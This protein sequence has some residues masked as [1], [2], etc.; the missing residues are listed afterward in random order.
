MN[1]LSDGVW[2][3]LYCFEMNGDEEDKCKKCGSPR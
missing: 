2:Q 1:R 3:C